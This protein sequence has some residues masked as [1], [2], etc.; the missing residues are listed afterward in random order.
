MTDNNT[1][2]LLGCYPVALNIL[3]ELAEED[4]GFKSFN[5]LNNIPIEIDH[6]I[7]NDDWEINVVNCFESQPVF[8]G[9]GIYALAVVGCRPKEIVYNHF[10]DLIGYGKDQ[11]INLIH[12][13]SYVSG[14]ASLDYG[15]QIEQLTTIAA[16]AKI[17]FGVNIKR[18]CNIGHH[19]ELEDFVTINP[20]VTMSSFVKVGKGTMI[21]SG[22]VI[23]DNI[24]IGKNSVIGI[25]SVVVKDVPD[26]CIAF[27]NPCKVHRFIT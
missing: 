25:G 14:S 23:K 3:L 24:T 21:G 20:G 11:F 27:G 7:P 9:D 5:I 12:P 2:N 26:N 16:C 19:C 8:N 18:N 10:K 17:G 4:K 13:T 6:F 1:L 22:T 15:L